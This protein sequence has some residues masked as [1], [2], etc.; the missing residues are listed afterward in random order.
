MIYTQPLSE[1]FHPEWR[2]LGLACFEVASENKAEETDTQALAN[3][4]E[5]QAKEN[6]GLD[7]H[8]INAKIE[9]IH[10]PFT[11]KAIM[12]ITGDLYRE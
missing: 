1:L 8:I 7:T 9:L 4:A 6:F 12:R 11:D 3:T 2:P 10:D 5:K